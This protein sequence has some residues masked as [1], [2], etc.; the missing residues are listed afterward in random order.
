MSD[1]SY[2]EQPV[3]PLENPY[4]TYFRARVREMEEEEGNRYL[5]EDGCGVGSPGLGHPNRRALDKSGRRTLP[6]KW[7]GEQWEYDDTTPG[8][9]NPRG[10]ALDYW[11]ENFESDQFGAYGGHL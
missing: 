6:L 1:E 11:G 5:Q 3:I 9:D 7:T 10:P 4:I 2:E 8:V